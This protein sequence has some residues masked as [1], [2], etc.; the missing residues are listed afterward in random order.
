LL[1]LTDL[2]FTELTAAAAAAVSCSNRQV[3]WVTGA[4]LCNGRRLKWYVI[5]R[6]AVIQISAHIQYHITTVNYWSMATHT[7]I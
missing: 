4:T 1:L 2:S 6:R 3:Y 5:Q 7:A